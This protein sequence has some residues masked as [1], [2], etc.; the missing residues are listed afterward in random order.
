MRVLGAL[1]AAACWW[2]A[3]AQDP[4]TE[5]VTV[6]TEHPRL[7]LRPQRLRLLRR[8]RERT[9]QRW[10]QFAALVTGNAP[11]P[12][13]GFAL[14]LYH[15]VTGD[16]AA[17]KE[18]IAF[19][20]GPSADLR[21]QALVYDWCQDSLSDA[22]RSSLTT[23]LEK[24]ITDPPS[25]GGVGMVRSR[26]LA[27]IALFDHVERAPQRELERVVRQ[28]WMG[29][30]VPALTAGRAAISRDD[31]YALFEM[32][33][34]LRDNTVL[35]LREAAPQ[36][37]KDYPIEHLMSYYP[38]VY[39]GPD[40]NYYIGAN[41]RGG[42]PD[43]R[44]AALSRAGELAMVAYDTNGAPSQVLQGWLMHDKFILRST[45]GAPYEFLWANPYLPGLS[46]YHVPL[47]YH[48]PDFGRLF[49]RSSWDDGAS[50]FGAFDG[51]T[52]LFA[53]GKLQQS[54]GGPLPLEQA[55][56][57]FAK[58]GDRFTVKPG[59]DEDAVFIVGL[60]PRK[61][62]EVEIDDEEMVEVEADTGGILELEVPK[63]K[64]VGIRFRPA[65][66]GSE[67]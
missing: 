66:T 6:S 54:G 49:I 26:V 40:T 9:S 1:L 5:P 23:K 51:V 29:R 55:V 44:V 21:Q 12:E 13:R 22:Q 36:F 48:N 53:D 3:A 18:A 30:T 7:L 28:W 63:G 20:L 60:A 34:A 10:E 4:A 11:M 32:L 64:T 41:Q 57:C 42:E 58:S 37:F 35:D 62:Y 56:V 61:V 33:H 25:D 67:R 27:A 46:Y 8:E 2:P 16:A 43:L 17:G 39:E 31:A 24:A 38:A 19:A 65:A 47:V 59:E 15:Q 14:A 50:W 52:Q 45:F